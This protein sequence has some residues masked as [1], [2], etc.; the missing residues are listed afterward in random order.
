MT[1]TKET[2]L[3]ALKQMVAKGKTNQCIYKYRA[4]NE[5]TEK[6]FNNHT[7]W[8]AHPNEF[9][10]PFDC[11]ANIQY[12]D[13]EGL[14]NLARRNTSSQQKLEVYRKGIERFT[15]EMLKKDVASVMNSLGIC[16]FSKNEKSILMWSNY[17]DCHKG[18]C[19]QFDIYE[20]PDF[21]TTTFPVNYVERMPVYD[22]FNE[23][24]KLVEKIIQ[25]KSRN[26]WSYEEEVRIVKT[27]SDILHNGNSQA[28]KFN[29]KSLQKIIFG[30]K[31]SDDTINKYKEFCNKD[32]QLE[33]VKFSKMAQKTD[34]LFE[35]VELPL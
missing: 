16:C 23:K 32:N 3:M 9:N 20:D 35:L 2:K 21:F 14:D 18:I 1:I 12:I 25:P 15:P 27:D 19:L 31:A 28:F 29:S 13:K 8:F 33:H 7:L 5:K 26:E 30:C 6:I 4:I 24:D 17:A 11:W 22:H 34:G 10:D